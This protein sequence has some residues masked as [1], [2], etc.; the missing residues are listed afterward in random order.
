MNKYLV[1][2]AAINDVQAVAMLLKDGCD[3]HFN[4]DMALRWAVSCR[5]FGAVELLLEVG[6]DV[7]ANDDE[8]LRCACGYG[9][10]EIVRVLLRAG[11]DVHA[12]E[13]EAIYWSSCRKHAGVVQELLRAGADVRQVSWAD[14]TGDVPPEGWFNMSA[15]ECIKHVVAGVVAAELTLCL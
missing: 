14:L 11:A 8:A 6:A 10:L 5:S 13:D 15:E 1:Q 3:V 7:H 9:Y 12:R 2:A 4:D